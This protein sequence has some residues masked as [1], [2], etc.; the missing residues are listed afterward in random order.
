MILIKEINK[1]KIKKNCII[2]VMVEFSKIKRVPKNAIYNKEEIYRLLDHYYLT[3]VGFVENNLPVVIPTLYGRE[4]DTIYLHGASVS[5]LMTTIENG[6]NVCLSIAEVQGLVLARSAFHHSLN[7]ES[8]VIFGKGRLVEDDKKNHALKVISDHLLLGRWEEARLPNK[9][10]LKATKVIAV[11]IEKISAKV[12][13]GAPK[14]E[15][16]DY[17]LDIWAGVIPIIK[18]YG[19]PIPDDKL[20]K[21]EPLPDSVKKIPK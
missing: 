1:K 4:K 20:Q 8:I 13:T 7:Y 11:D 12:R 3:H 9:M 14:D 18:K 19:D 16:E 2:I 6:V 17:E 5:R 21:K 10:E 15:A